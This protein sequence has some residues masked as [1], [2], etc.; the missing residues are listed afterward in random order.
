MSVGYESS[1]ETDGTRK[2]TNLYV[3]FSYLKRAFVQ[4]RATDDDEV[5]NRAAMVDYVATGAGGVTSVAAGAGLVA[6]PSPI[7]STGSLSLPTTGITAGPYPY[8][9]SVTFDA[10]GRA[11]AATAGSAP[12]VY[13][14]APRQIDVTGTVIGL[15][16]VVH[17][18]AVDNYNSTGADDG[19]LVLGASRVDGSGDKVRSIVLGR[20]GAGVSG[21]ASL[22]E[23]IFAGRG[24]ITGG[25]QEHS[26]YLTQSVFDVSCQMTACLAMGNASYTGNSKVGSIFFADNAST[27]NTQVQYSIIGGFHVDVNNQNCVNGCMVMGRDINMAGG[28]MSSGCVVLG[29]N[30]LTNLGLFNGCFVAGAGW[31]NLTS[32]VTSQFYLVHNYTRASNSNISACAKAV[33][34]AT[35]SGRTGVFIGGG[36]QTAGPYYNA[37]FPGT[38][39]LNDANTPAG[40]FVSIVA[41]G[42]VRIASGTGAETRFEV[43]RPR[44]SE[45]TLPSTNP[46]DLVSRAYADAY[47]ATTPANWAG[48]APTTIQDAIDR[49]A[50]AYNALHGAVP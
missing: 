8:P 10:F 22:V 1:V 26:L 41:G 15:T 3:D 49:L 21:T 45:A 11:T 19:L 43:N 13:T 27:C 14:G 44:C 40:A 24:L 37:S 34:D 18:G 5:V 50:A 28:Q 32:N 16:D 39:Y 7:T 30:H 2:F 23:S 9:A 38:T 46:D 47:T 48:A 6:S 33:Y 4:K 42:H 17:I 29:N 31:S 25:V 12:P 36:A 20:A 35:S